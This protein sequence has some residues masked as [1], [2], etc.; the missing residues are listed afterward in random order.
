MIAFVLNQNEFATL[1]NACVFQNVVN[2]I[3]FVLLVLV[4]IIADPLMQKLVQPLAPLAQD[5]HAP[6]AVDSRKRQ[7]T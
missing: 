6:L 3:P 4:S 2:V 7:T 5:L 1:V